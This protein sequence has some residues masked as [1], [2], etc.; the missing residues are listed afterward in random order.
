VS[1][2]DILA[3]IKADLGITTNTDDAFL[4][5]RINGVW[6]LMERYTGRALSIP[7]AQFID[8]WGRI[9]RVNGQEPLPL[10]YRF[11]PRATVFL[12]YVP[13]VSIDA[14]EIDGAASPA[15]GVTFDPKTGKLF[16]LTEGHACDVSHRLLQARAKITYKAG[17]AQVPADLYE[18]VMSVV[19]VAYA[20]K[21]SGGA[22]GMPG[23]ISAINVT[24]VGSVDV[25]SGSPFV[26]AATK[27]TGAVDPILGPYTSVLDSYVDHRNLQIGSAL[28]PVT[29]AVPEPPP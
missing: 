27:G 3:D 8:D 10:S 5:R 15:A 23:T 19:Q 28:F 25:A 9:V 17:W 1:A 29:E 14:L 26:Q 24:D 20:G 7:P 12:R 2:P 6:A 11:L 22:T 18:I 4:Q 13:V 16:T 21:Q